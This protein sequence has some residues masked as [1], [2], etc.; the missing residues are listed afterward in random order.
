MEAVTI[1]LRVKNDP[2]LKYGNSCIPEELAGAPEQ[3]GVG[4]IDT[5]EAGV[6][7]RFGS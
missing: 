6:D 3:M 7:V 2:G 4:E 1:F 5:N